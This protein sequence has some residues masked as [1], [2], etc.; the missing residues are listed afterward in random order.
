VTF[1]CLVTGDPAL[2]RP[3]YEQGPAI[4][5]NVRSRS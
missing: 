2:Q 5:V 3:S 4:N 1:R